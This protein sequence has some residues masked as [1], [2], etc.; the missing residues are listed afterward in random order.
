MAVRKYKP[1]V[2]PQILLVEVWGTPYGQPRH[3]TRV[4]FP[5]DGGKAFSRAYSKPDDR[6]WG[7]RQSVIDAFV[8]KARAVGW[9]RPESGVPLYLYIDLYFLRP[10]SRKATDL[11]MTSRPDDDNLRKAVSD[12]LQDQGFI[13]DD[14]GIVHGW[15]RKLYTTD[16]PGAKM[17]LVSGPPTP[18]WLGWSVETIAEDWRA[19]I[20]ERSTE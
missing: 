8:K 4:V 10:K 18:G 13:A 1:A 16:R 19:Q 5:K 17:L 2:V 7:W 20:A 9:E 15:T 11:V 12:C 6:V 3:R 14:A